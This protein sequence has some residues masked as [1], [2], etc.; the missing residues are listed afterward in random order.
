MAKE[1]LEQK[2]GNLYFELLKVESNIAMLQEKYKE[3]KDKIVPIANEIAKME[4][5]LPKAE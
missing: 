5:V 1:D 2:L 3:I 4:G